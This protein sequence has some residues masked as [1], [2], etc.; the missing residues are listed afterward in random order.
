[1]KKK[2]IMCFGLWLMLMAATACSNDKYNELIET[3]ISSNTLLESEIISSIPDKESC[4]R[5]ID[6][7]EDL[8][9]YAADFYK[10]LEDN[11]GMDGILADFSKAERKGED[12]CYNIRNITD[13]VIISMEGVSDLW[14]QIYEV[15]NLRCEKDFE[16]TLVYADS[17]FYAFEYDNPQV[18][19][20]G[21]EIF[22]SWYS[23]WDY[24]IDGEDCLVTYTQSIYFVLKGEEHD[25]RSS[26]YI[27]YEKLQEDMVLFE[28]Q[29]EKVMTA[30]ENMSDYEKIRFFNRWLVDQN[31][32][33]AMEGRDSLP[34]STETAVSAILGGKGTEGPICSAYARAFKVFCDRTRIPCLLIDGEVITGDGTLARHEWNQVKMPDG[35][36][37]AVDVTW[38]DPVYEEGDEA[39]SVPDSTAERYLLVGQDTIV[40]DLV[41]SQSHMVSDM[42]SEYAPASFFMDDIPVLAREKYHPSED[43]F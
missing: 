41:F 3:D 22:R 16:E 33:N 11:S 1:M 24:E 32:Y 35:N 18:F 36:W 4:I 21:N 19:W 42:V 23:D 9:E 15:V 37:Y 30:C 12:Y 34:R 5:W 31:Q 40:S 14:S 25:L 27:E 26:E 6:C 2:Y 38:N 13:T 43:G 28:E 20:L 17:A 10:W 39:G 29:V 8:P 7:I